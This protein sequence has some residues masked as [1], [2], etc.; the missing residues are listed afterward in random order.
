MKCVE[1]KFLRILIAVD[2]FLYYHAEHYE[3]IN[4]NF[5]N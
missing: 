2:F 1:E 5:I 3:C 4:L